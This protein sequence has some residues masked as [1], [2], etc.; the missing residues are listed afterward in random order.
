M[1]K[2]WEKPDNAT[3]IQE[4]YRFLPGQDGLVHVHDIVTYKDGSQKVFNR[5][6]LGKLALGRVEDETLTWEKGK[7][8]VKGGG[9]S[10]GKPNA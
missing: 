4:I 6:Y 8:K 9:K 3:A 5:L 10:G 1:K 7:I 2:P